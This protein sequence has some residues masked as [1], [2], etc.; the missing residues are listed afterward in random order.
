MNYLDLKRNLPIIFE[1][2]F[3]FE[4]VGWKQVSDWKIMVVVTK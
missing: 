3:P 1:R 4:M 2:D